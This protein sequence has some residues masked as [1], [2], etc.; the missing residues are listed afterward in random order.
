MF[1]NILF[2]FDNT[3]YDYESA[4]KEALDT[5]FRKLNENFNLNNVNDAYEKEKKKFQNY[6]SNASSHNKFIQL[7]KIF[8][9]Y[10]LDLNQLN[11]YY[12][13]YINVFKSNLKL[14]PG[15]LEFLDLCTRNGI[16]MYI[17]TNNT[18]KEQIERLQKLDLLKYFSKVYT[19]EEFGIEKPDI[20]L[21]YYVIQDINCNK[22]EIVK[23]GDNY[24]NDIEP[25][26]LNNIYSFWFNDNFSINNSYLEFDSYNNLLILFK[27]YY[28]N[29]DNFLYISNY[30]GER[31]DLVQAGGGNTSFK[32]DDIMFIKSS[33]CHLS[34][35]DINKNYVGLNY[36]NIVKK[37]KNINDSDKKNR[38]LKSK[39][40]VESNIIFF[41]NNKPSIETTLHCLTKK[42]TVHI[43]PIQFNYI[44]SLANCNTI[45]EKIFKDFC[46]I[47]YFTPGIDVAL[48]LLK[49]Y[50]NESIIFMKNHGLVVTADTIYEIKEL[51]YNIT[52]KLE[53][54][55]K[56]DYSKYHLVNH[57]SE[58]LQAITKQKCV[59]YLSNNHNILE[60]IK[61]KYEKDLNKYFKSFLPDKVVYCGSHYIYYKI[62]DIIKNKIKKYIEKY[63]EIPKIFI[64]ERDEKKYLY[65]S[66]N[67]LN[68]CRE[69]EEVLIS[70]LICYNDNN[71]F[72]S[73]NEIEYLNNWDA[74]K[75][76]KNLNN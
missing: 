61:N 71:T 6:C 16:K 14:Y 58:N 49:K 68:K 8:E 42:Y 36:K 50:N 40:I 23:I 44:S 33:G 41:K 38:E 52:N 57:F 62:K 46:V 7:K 26:I 18:C 29:L 10:N 64:M 27:Q 1:K 70:H 63:H 12:D 73:E 55:L 17:L 51:L 54:E 60:F 15:L 25:L 59:T 39:E 48:E 5:V 69:I 47:N 3:L 13:L 24:K 72:L 67:S 75:Y 2:D 31:F 34:N 66:S 22:N 43:H 11:S 76:R 53:K 30:V 35:M 32:T 37:I 9:K 4:N 65:I 56:L 19:S 74:E 21:F 20:K 45:L 28:S